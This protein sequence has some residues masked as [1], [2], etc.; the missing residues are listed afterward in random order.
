MFLC[1]L[2]E[3]GE[4]V[5]PMGFG[6]D[7]VHEDRHEHWQV[8]ECRDALTS[9]VRIVEDY[10]KHA[11]PAVGFRGIVEDGDGKTEREPD[12]PGNET[13][14]GIECAHGKNYGKN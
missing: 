6:V 11:V 5:A 7:C 4:N 13:K 1:R 2:G 8:H 3:Y 14:C 10:A 9:L 12:E